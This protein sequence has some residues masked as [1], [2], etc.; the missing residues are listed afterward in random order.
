ME[1]IKDETIGFLISSLNSGGAER[2]VSL[3][4]NEMSLTKKV[5]VITLSNEKPF[6]QLNY[7][8]TIK[9]LRVLNSGTNPLKSIFS[10]LV[11]I[12]KITLLIRSLKIKS[13]ICFMPTSNILGIIS[14]KLLSKIKVTI[15]E[16]AN[17]NFNDLGYWNFLRRK[18]YK[19][20]DRLVVQS[21]E[22]SN[23][24]KSFVDERKISIIPNPIKIVDSNKNKN[25]NIILTVGRVDANKNQEQ[26][27]RSFSRVKQEGWKLIICGDGPL[28]SKLKELVIALH[29][30]DAVEFKGIVKNIEKQYERASIFAFSSLS[31]GFPN[32]LLEAMNH[33]CACISTDC[34]TG[35]RILIKH[36]KNG[37]LIPSGDEYLYDKYLQKLVD[38]EKLRNSFLKKSR[39]KLIDYELEKISQQWII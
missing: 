16:R 19:L 29:I 25:E 37:F 7:S 4:A 27:I 3:L 14:G 24:F 12:Y 33:D 17:P 32:V 21:E 26:I 15:S 11:L 35:P 18:T 20:A 1:I 38:D 5:V 10:N 28:V 31:E 39:E 34:F 8:I 36:N 22:I 2:V 30:N 23:Y 6:Y 13:L 9:Q